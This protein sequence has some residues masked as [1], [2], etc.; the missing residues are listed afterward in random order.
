MLKSLVG[1]AESL[2]A[3]N[4]QAVVAYAPVVA[5]IV[6]SGS[7][8]VRR[9]EHALDGLLD[10]CGYQPALALYKELC[11]HYWKINP[12]ATANYIYA[13]RDIWDS[14]KKTPPKRPAPARKK[15]RTTK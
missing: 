11:R 9:I 5:D 15:R 7:R 3:L 12:R 10:F 8:N 6:R 2:E 4:E 13:Y 1:L 14:E